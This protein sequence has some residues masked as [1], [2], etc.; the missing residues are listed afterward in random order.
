MATIHQL[1]QAILHLIRTGCEAEAVSLFIL[2]PTAEGDYPLLVHSDS[3]PAVPELADVEQA[4]AFLASLSPD[5]AQTAPIPSSDKNGQLT[6]VPSLVTLVNGQPR[7]A[8]MEDRRSANGTACPGTLVDPRTPA[9]LGIRGGQAVNPADL[10]K[11]A[12][13]GAMH[14]LYLAIGSL[15]GCRTQMVCTAEMDPISQ[16]PSRS[17]FPITYRRFAAN[18]AQD[19]RPGLLL[20]NPDDFNTVNDRF[21]REIGDQVIREIARR[22]SEAV[23]GTDFVFRYGAAMFGVLIPETT[24]RK[25][26]CFA[27]KIRGELSADP[28]RDGSIS[29]TFSLGG[30]VDQPASSTDND[31]GAMELARRADAALSC[32]KRA[33]GQ[34]FTLWTEDVG[35]EEAN[36]LDSLSGIFTADPSKDYRNMR[37]LWDT[38]RLIAASADVETMMD[39]LL[40]EV[41]SVFS[42]TAAGVY[43]EGPAGA[44]WKILRREEHD[45][46]GEWRQDSTED[47]GLKAI[48]QRVMARGKTVAET[49]EKIDLFRCVIPLC[50]GER[51]LGCLYLE[52]NVRLFSLNSGDLLF[53]E[54]LAE[55]IAMAL[56]RNRLTAIEMRQH[57]KACYQLQHELD[58][59]QKS[60]KRSSLIFRSE[61][62]EQLLRTA[63]RLAATDTTVLINGE[64]GTGKEV[65]ARTIHQLSKRSKKP[66]VIVD[67]SAITTSLIDSELFGHERGAFTGADRRSEGRLL[68]ADG[69]TVLLDEIGELPLEVQSKLLR[70]VQE[71]QFTPVGSNQVKTVDVRVIALTN[72]NLAVESRDG[73]FRED[74]FHRLNVMRLVVPALRDRVEDID[75]LA[76]HF[77]RTFSMRYDRHVTGLTP[78]GREA[79]LKHS[80]PGNVR[81]LQNRIMRAVVLAESDKITAGELELSGASPADE[82]HRPTEVRAATP[83]KET[84]QP[85]DAWAAL[86]RSLSSEIDRIVAGNSP[87]PPPVG[88]W[89]HE[90]LV[91][92][93]AR[94]SRE[95]TAQGAV[96]LGIPETTFRRKLRAAS[97][98]MAAGLAIRPPA[99]EEVRDRIISLLETG[100]P[101]QED[102]LDLARLCILDELSGKIPGDNRTGAA[103]MG[104]TETT[105]KKWSNGL[106]PAGGDRHE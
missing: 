98:N 93:A 43:D 12:G 85:D 21:N 88:K 78:D 70:F 24:G 2:L 17:S 54:A 84:M 52:G 15:I 61:A 11:S 7:D 35:T 91:L 20:I 94:A 80:W 5:D 60:I 22:V 103:F 64:S 83:A 79:L 97:G 50:S 95:V 1:L 49:D 29:L 104:V 59:L 45:D 63:K 33:G 74:L 39:S 53:F 101:G 14:S 47:T 36:R 10:L 3:E 4:Q 44:V 92:E 27:D 67:C 65:L 8:A 86:R 51:T 73:R 68:E 69:G 48:R 26:S 56:D 19:R 28:Y 37:L 77:I 41:V 100:N 105:F 66:L 9:W 72:R 58:E 18:A 55:Q 102:V 6:F 71:K 42:L 25:I 34:R 81:E 40:Q 90:D 76:I 57:E 16:L 46:D 31:G 87:H 75:Y 99:W 106:V 82:P 89:V 13:D 32:A 38:V 30:A 23:R 62:M 96:L